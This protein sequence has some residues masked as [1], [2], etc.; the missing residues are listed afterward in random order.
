MKQKPSE[1]RQSKS[2]RKLGNERISSVLGSKSAQRLGFEFQLFSK[3]CVEPL[4][5]VRQGHGRIKQSCNRA[6]I[7]KYLKRSAKI[8]ETLTDPIRSNK[9]VR[10]GEGT[11]SEDSWGVP[12]RGSK[13]PN[14][15][16]GGE[17]MPFGKGEESLAG[18]IG[19]LERRLSWS[20]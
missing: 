10:I 12:R 7:P 6:K 8:S 14:V 19:V 2:Q 16:Q 11:W 3:R 9:L 4:L 5:S 1:R 13:T 17:K 15:V 20:R 18:V